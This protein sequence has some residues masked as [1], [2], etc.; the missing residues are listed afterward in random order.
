MEPQWRDLRDV[1]RSSP[2]SQ[3]G[4]ASMSRAQSTGQPAPVVLLFTDR[5]FE[6]NQIHC[7]CFLHLHLP[8]PLPY[9]IFNCAARS[10]YSF[11]ALCTV[12]S[13]SSLACLHFGK[14]ACFALFFLLFWM[15][16]LGFGLTIQTPLMLTVDSGRD[17][18]IA[19][20]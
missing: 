4:M 10:Y 16:S 6:P 7:F 12:L 1:V 3:S 18:T 13:F 15:P 11:W 17:T 9:S 8:S 19:A 20:V 14:H 5:R 2:L